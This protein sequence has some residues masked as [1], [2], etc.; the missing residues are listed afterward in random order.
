MAQ[1]IRY[2]FGHISGKPGDDKSYDFFEKGL[3][4][5]VIIENLG[6]QW[7]FLEISHALSKEIG[8]FF[9]GFLV[10]FKTTREEV[11]DAGGISHDIVEDHVRAKSRFF[12]HI[13]SG[14]V[15]Y[16]PITNFIER[17][18]F[19]K[20]F[21]RLFIKSLHNLAAEVK[22][23]PREEPCNLQQVMEELDSIKKITLKLQKPNPRHEDMWKEFEKILEEMGAT[24]YS[25]IIENKKSES[26]DYSKIA[27]IKSKL[28]LAESEYGMGEIVGFK[29]G[30]SIT[31][32]S[33]ENPIT[34]N[35]DRDIE[36][37]EDIL[38]ELIPT[39]SRILASGVKA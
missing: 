18:Y 39:F 4:K 34:V 14:I 26:L 21:E 23:T 10:K 6:Y 27:H 30:K 8:K 37:P 5:D 35:V 29:N 28:S 19:C 36:K 3:N 15:A 16:N 32:R 38:A 22:V 13:D 1:K 33:K 25:E 11:V 12:I 17:N 20:I 2:F 31:V 9:T 7:R 24:H